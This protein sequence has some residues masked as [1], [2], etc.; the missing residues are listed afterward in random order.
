MVSWLYHY[1]VL[2]FLG[3]K[4]YFGWMCLSKKEF[5][6]SW[7]PTTSL[8]LLYYFPIR[9][10]NQHYP[11]S[12]TVSFLISISLFLT[13]FFIFSHHLYFLAS[14][15]IFLCIF[16]IDLACL[17]IFYASHLFSISHR[18]RFVSSLRTFRKFLTSIPT[19]SSFPF[20]SFSFLVC[21]IQF[22]N[23]FLGS[24]LIFFFHRLG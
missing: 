13:F 2:F 10:P 19:F 17:L 20:L 4:N 18:L 15:P 23:S 8:C 9:V 1:I 12:F 16:L 21:F 14:S 3:I 5:V 6:R 22:F 11:I 24:L 7:Y